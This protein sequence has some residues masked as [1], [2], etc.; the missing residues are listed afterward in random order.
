MFP[1][2]LLEAE[3]LRVELGFLRRR[4]SEMEARRLFSEVDTLLSVA[5]VEV[6]R[7]IVEL[8]QARP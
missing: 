4:I 7:L 1:D 5:E 8:R 3:A 6:D 2:Q